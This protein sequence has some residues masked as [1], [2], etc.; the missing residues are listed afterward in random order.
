MVHTSL[1]LVHCH[2]HTVPRTNRQAH[3][4]ILIH[5][6][7]LTLSPPTPSTT[8]EGLH[9][10]V[11]TSISILLLKLY[12]ITPVPIRIP[13]CDMT[14]HRTHT[15]HIIT[16]HPSPTTLTSHGPKKTSTPSS[17][18]VP[19]VGRLFD[20]SLGSFGFPLEGD[21][22]DSVFDVGEWGAAGGGDADFGNGDGPSGSGSGSK[23][24]SASASASISAATSGSAFDGLGV[25]PDIWR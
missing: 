21:G 3:I 2:I 4:P 6:L 25:V 14:P 15:I 16:P 20:G 12:L 22:S 8:L 19:D 11:Y 7:P 24:V 10:L 1:T 9:Y 13:A 18:C 23:A 17:Q 5:K